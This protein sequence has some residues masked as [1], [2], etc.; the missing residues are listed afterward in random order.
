MGDF[1]ADQP[2]DLFAGRV[3]DVDPAAI[4]GF[5]ECDKSLLGVFVHADHRSLSWQATARNIG[6][7][8]VFWI[9]AGVQIAEVYR[10]NPFPF[11]FF[12]NKNASRKVVPGAGEP[13][14]SRSD[15]PCQS[16]EIRAD[17]P[18][19]LH[20]VSAHCY[21][22]ESHPSPQSKAGIVRI[23]SLALAM[24]K[25]LLSVANYTP[26]TP[27]CVPVCCPPHPMYLVL[28]LQWPG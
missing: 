20:Y 8:V 2:G 23:G 9:S 15:N 6:V 13:D 14:A 7:R 11:S 21:A 5:V 18:Q 17:P 16:I 22:W 28:Q 25:H 26:L 3:N 19:Y 27:F 1:L 10:P 4:D 12:E 24:F